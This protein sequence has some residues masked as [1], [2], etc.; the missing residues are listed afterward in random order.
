MPVRGDMDIPS[1]QRQ[2]QRAINSISTGVEHSH[3][4][5]NKPEPRRISTLTC[6][7]MKR[8]ETSNSD[9]RKQS[10]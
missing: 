9:S 5:K 3:N 7:G 8:F 4:A 10:F 2:H 6:G 1:Q